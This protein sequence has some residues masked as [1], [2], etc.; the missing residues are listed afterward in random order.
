MTL[1]LSEVYGAPGAATLT[2]GELQSP[3]AQEGIEHVRGGSISK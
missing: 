1:P 2:V 3:E